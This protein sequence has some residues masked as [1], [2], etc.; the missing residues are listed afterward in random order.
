MIQT[1]I[2]KI[3]NWEITISD[4]GALNKI[5]PNKIDYKSNS[6]V[7]LF[8]G[9]NE[10]IRIN[11][12]SGLCDVHQLHQHDLLLSLKDSDGYDH[13]VPAHID[14]IDCMIEW[15]KSRNFNLKVF[16]ENISFSILGNI[17]DVTSLA[18]E[19]SYGAI[20]I[21]DLATVF[22]TS[23]DV[24]ENHFPVGN[25]SSYQ[26]LA[27]RTGDIPIVVLAHVFIG[28]IVCEE[29]NRGD[30][31]HCRLVRGDEKQTTQLGGVMPIAYY[32]AK[33]FGWGIEM[34]KSAR[35]LTR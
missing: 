23:I 7:C 14:I 34:G 33:T 16:F 18:N 1:I 5:N 2:H 8:D 13:S 29:A 32:A 3:A 11:R 9:C 28:L 19:V 17:P 30:R 12:T 10:V 35:L 27:T 31:W 6:R 15:A 24:A 26:P 21:P 20:P 25:N 22:S 4:K